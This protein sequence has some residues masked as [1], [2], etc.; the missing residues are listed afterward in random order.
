MSISAK[1]KRLIRL[2][3]PVLIDK[4]SGLVS[5]SKKRETSEECGMSKSLVTKGSE[6]VDLFMKFGLTQELCQD[7]LQKKHIP[8]QHV[9]IKLNRWLLM[10][11]VINW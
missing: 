11:F 9:P 10:A 5:K 8:P 7:P 4:F 6:H 2:I 3:P 1:K